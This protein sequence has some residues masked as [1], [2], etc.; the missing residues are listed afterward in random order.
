MEM[1]LNLEQDEVT[2]SGDNDLHSFSQPV[3]H[4]LPSQLKN[5]ELLT[6]L[7]SYSELLIVVSGTSGIGKTTLAQALAAQREEPEET[8][9]LNGDIMLGMPAIL[10][11]L[12]SRWDL[13]QLPDDVAES[14]EAVKHA[15]EQRFA[16]GSST[17]VIIDQAEQLDEGT[18]NDIAHFA[19]LAPQ[20][21]SFALFGSPGFE[22]GFRESPTQAPIHHLNITPLTLEEADQLAKQIFGIGAVSED[23]IQFAFQNSSGLALIFLRELEDILLAD[24]PS[25]VDKQISKSAPRFPLTHV[26]GVAVVAAVL[27]ISYLYRFEETPQPSPEEVLLQSLNQPAIE[28]VG[29]AGEAVENDS[30]IFTSDQQAEMKTEPV[31]VLDAAPEPDFNYGAPL[32][33]SSAAEPVVEDASVS[34]EDGQ[35]TEES[36]EASIQ[37]EAPLVEVSPESLTDQSALSRDE[38]ILMNGSGFIA[39]LLG[40]HNRANANAFVQRWQGS[41]KGQLYLYETIHKGKPWYV[42]VAGLYADRSEAKQAVAAMP[43]VL[44]KQSP[45]VRNLTAV[46]KV[47]TSS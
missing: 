39:Q 35:S 14:K 17:L 33:D 34:D 29:P 27:L 43:G 41:V 26:I 22:G 19:L 8:V 24:V 23:Q 20:A 3:V 45:W 25:A 40:S 31:A 36:A 2:L 32:A 38:S 7:A 12:A 13:S 28:S 16:G 11:A 9:F 15:A 42:V 5:L 47:I 10:S 44:R 1:D 4:L 46:K 30:E 37:K 18:L 6:H 21:I